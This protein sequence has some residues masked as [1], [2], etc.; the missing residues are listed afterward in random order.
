MVKEK[1]MEENAHLKF[2][3]INPK[4]NPLSISKGSESSESCIMILFTIQ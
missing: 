2:S 4:A 3:Q 1:I